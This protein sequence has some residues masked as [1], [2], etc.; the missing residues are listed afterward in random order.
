[1]SI[2]KAYLE[3]VL[4]DIRFAVREMLRSPGFAI[5]VVAALAVCI[6]AN[7]AIFSVV[8]AVLFRPLPFPNQDRL[9]SL[10]EGIPAAG[11][12]V[13]PFSC[14]DYLYVTA[15]NRSFVSTASYR[16][17]P[18][19]ISGAGE[20]RQIDGAR[21][22]ASLFDVLQ[23]RPLFGRSF[24]KQEDDSSKPLVVLTYA[25]A[26][27]LFS[28]PQRAL[29]KV[30]RID[31]KPY[32]VIGV[33]G[34]AFSFPLK[35]S[36][37]S[38]QPAELFVPVSWTQED[39]KELLNNFDY[40]MIARLRP[41]VL[42]P[43]A[44]ADVR[45][46]LNNLAKSYPPAVLTFIRQIPNFALVSKVSLFRKQVTGNVRRPLLLL[47]LAVGVVLLIGCADVA[48]LMF[49]RVIGRQREFALRSALGAGTWRLVRQTLA[50]GLVLSAA[51][52]ALGLA[53]AMGALPALLRFAPDNLP[54]L[55]EVGLDW[56]V[57]SFVAAIT[58][59]TPLVFCVAPLLDVVRPAAR[60][61]I[62]LAGRSNTQGKRQRLIMSVAV[63]A[64]FSLAFLLLATA[65]L[66]VRS[67]I[68]AN[69]SNPASGL[70]IWSPFG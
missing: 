55:N 50:A 38:G 14:S 24:T 67:F 62:R 48:N 34:P 26:T 2:T 30:L 1:M 65:G 69:E 41:D 59:A 43:Q 53:L 54:R 36:K 51:G 27:N 46:L 60:Q 3:D 56:R 21:I 8:D 28:Q 58:L 11:F 19:E 49:S 23:V 68:K 37:F 16:T 29:G 52:G 63:V 18:Y 22:T 44:A 20:P 42:V 61:Q 45:Q 70:N 39:R 64:Q 7:T 47:L 4:A 33:M 5:V 17:S 31:R 12:P 13:V 10:T 66:L 15:R 57:L 35:G 25:F 9:V 32:T 40:N 6:G